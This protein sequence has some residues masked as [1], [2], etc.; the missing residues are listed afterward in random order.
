[1]HRIRQRW[2]LTG[3]QVRLPPSSAAPIYARERPIGPRPQVGRVE[4]PEEVSVIDVALTQQPIS[5]P[6]RLSHGPR[7]ES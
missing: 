7:S 3:T 1:M 4:P 6:A 5:Y 2:L